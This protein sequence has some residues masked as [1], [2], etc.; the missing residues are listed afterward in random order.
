MSGHWL[1]LMLIFTSE[2]S[3]PEEEVMAQEIQ[4]KE[5][6]WYNTSHHKGAGGFK[7]IYGRQEFPPVLKAIKWLAGKIIDRG[8][9]SDTPVRQINPQDFSV[10]V[11]RFR[12]FW[13]GHSTTLIQFKH[14]NILIDPNLNTYAGL[15][16]FAG[17]KRLIPLPIEIDGLPEIDI[18]LISHSHYD[19]LDKKT[20]IALSRKFAPL[21]FVP[22]NMGGY[23]RSWGVENVVEMDWWQFVEIDGIRLSCVPAVHFSNRGVNDRDRVLWSGWYIEELQGAV[24]IYY[25]GDTAYSR[26]FKEIGEKLSPP[27]LAILPIGAYEPRWFMKNAHINPEEAIKAF[28]DLKAN[29][30]LGVHWGT[31]RLSD[32]P[33]DEPP[34]LLMKYA[35][36]NK[37]GDER[38]H[39]IPVGGWIEE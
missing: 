1:F 15:S 31:F 18:V 28:I 10:P 13:L 39:I 26:H 36:K 27:E 38:I 14:K 33:M 19:H 24:K 32:E 16:E 37:I 25:S 22:L 35:K 4:I 29:E 20:V 3:I 9:R 21:F 7:N 12:I 17:R 5:Y 34:E 2:I 6:P 8:G 30:F 11:T 23:L